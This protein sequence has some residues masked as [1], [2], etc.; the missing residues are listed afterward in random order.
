MTKDQM[1]LWSPKNAVKW[2]APLKNKP[3]DPS[4]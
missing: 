1:K 4:T 3:S 2:K